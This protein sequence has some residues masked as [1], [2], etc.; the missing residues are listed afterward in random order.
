MAKKFGKF[1]MTTAALGAIAAS[2]Y[3]FLW[4]KDAEADDDFDE[5][6]DYDWDDMEDEFCEDNGECCCTDS[7]VDDS[8]KVEQV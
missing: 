2:A 4:K 6:W 3:Y 1:L 7:D 5:D 8:V